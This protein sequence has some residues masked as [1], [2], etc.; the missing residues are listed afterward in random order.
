MTAVF[1]DGGAAELLPFCEAAID[2]LLVRPG[3]DPG[4]FRGGALW[5]GASL[6]ANGCAVYVLGAGRNN[7]EWW[8]RTGRWLAAVLPNPA[9]ALRDVQRLRRHRFAWVS[10]EGTS[11]A[12]ARAKVYWRLGGELREDD[13]DVPLLGSDTLREFAHAMLDGRD[14]GAQSVV[15][16]AGYRLAGGD[17][18]DVKI[19]VCGHCAAR[20]P[21]EWRELVKVRARAA[22]IDDAPLQTALAAPGMAVSFLGLGRTRDG[23]HRLN[24]YLNCQ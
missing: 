8:D 15:F 6:A 4:S 18:Y 22:G 11:V 12:D 7:A 13:P 14:A 9:D 17:A 10:V 1:S 23:E 24:L 2:E 19:D 5:L 3:V 21:A 16:S 20:D